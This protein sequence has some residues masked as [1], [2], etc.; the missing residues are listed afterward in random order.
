MRYIIS[1]RMNIL[2]IIN[3]LVLCSGRTKDFDVCLFAWIGHLG[4]A[5][6][7]N[8]IAL[9]FQNIKSL[10]HLLF[11]DTKLSFDSGSD[12]DHAFFRNLFFQKFSGL[13]C[14]IHTSFGTL[15]QK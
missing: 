14:L 3:L 11:R 6:A 5:T 15:I 7:I 1:D 8:G 12:I 9:H 13:L 10:V 4:H 2:K